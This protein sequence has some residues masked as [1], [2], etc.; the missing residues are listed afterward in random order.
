MLARTALWMAFSKAG[1]ARRMLATEPRYCLVE[2]ALRHG[3]E[4]DEITVKGWVRSSRKQKN[5]NFVNLVDGSSQQALQIVIDQGPEA[6]LGG[7]QTSTSNGSCWEITGTLKK[8]PETESNKTPSL[9]LHGS[10]LRLL[11]ECP[12]ATYPLQKKK[13]SPEFLR[14]IGH[15]RCRTRMINAVSRMR[16]VLQLSVHQVLHHQGFLN[17]HT[18]LITGSDCEGAGELFHVVGDPQKV[19]NTAIKA[20][21]QKQAEGKIPSSVDPMPKWDSCWDKARSNFFGVPTF[22]TVSGQLHLEAFSMGLGRVYCFGPTFRAEPSHTTQHLAEFWMLEPEIA[23]GNLQ[24]CTR[25][26]EAVV[27]YCANRLM[28]LCPDEIAFLN[29]TGDGRLLPR[30]QH[31]SDLYDLQLSQLGLIP[32]NTTPSHDGLWHRQDVLDSSIPAF[33]GFSR[34]TYHEA[35]NILTKEEENGAAK[36]DT[37]PTWDSGLSREHELHLAEKVFGGKPLFVTHYPQKQK[38]FYM[39]EDEEMSRTTPEPVVACMD[40]LIPNVG[41]LAGGSERESD[42]DKLVRSMKSRNI[43]PQHPSSSWYLD[44]RRFG[45]APHAGFGIGFDRLVQYL[46]GT[47]NIRDVIP[48]PRYAGSCLY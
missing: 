16:H 9:E 39:K 40:L 22:L 7:S 10:R 48:M 36:F 3:K 8:T 17:V 20:I 31:L 27:L 33:S 47:P 30:L 41:E 15:L 37:K 2:N 6:S 14:T 23:F 44:L 11:G 13:H 19:V 45:S 4:G 34:I 26:S 32:N 46:T 24:D 29:E 21:K 43:D 42:Y 18:P 28:A 38:A 35:L 12:G 1:G 25:L 5:I